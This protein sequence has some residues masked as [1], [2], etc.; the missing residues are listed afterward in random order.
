MLDGIEFGGIRRE[1]F[2]VYRT[3]EDAFVD[4]LAL[5]G[6]EGIADGVRS[7]SRAAGD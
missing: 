7:P 2:Q 4:E 5:V 3:M 6:V 1:I